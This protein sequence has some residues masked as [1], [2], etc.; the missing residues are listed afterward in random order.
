M[1]PLTAVLAQNAIAELAYTA[2]EI[3]QYVFIAAGENLDAA[4]IGLGTG[5]ALDKLGRPVIEKPISPEE[6]R[7]VTQATLA[8]CHNGYYVL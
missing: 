4:R 8:D 2:A 7:R 1:L 5:S 6:M 3:A